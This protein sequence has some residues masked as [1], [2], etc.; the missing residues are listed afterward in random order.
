MTITVILYTYGICLHA[1]FFIHFD[2][3]LCIF[4]FHGVR[5]KKNSIIISKQQ[6]VETTTPALIIMMITTLRCLLFTLALLYFHFQCFFF[7]YFVF[8]K[9]IFMRL[10]FAISKYNILN[11]TE[12]KKKK[13]CHMFS[14]K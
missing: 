3:L 9:L 1:T 4:Q 7:S 2:F 12:K 8:V 5:E 11:I 13:K 6:G 14:F 10:T